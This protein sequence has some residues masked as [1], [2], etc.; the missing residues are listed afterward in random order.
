MAHL[1]GH[2]TKCMDKRERQIKPHK[3][4]GVL[5][6]TVD[7]LLKEDKHYEVTSQR[8][9]IDFVLLARCDCFILCSWNKCVWTNHG[10]KKKDI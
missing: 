7:N 4:I 2:T 3:Y 6:G 5:R 1:P 8:L 10:L 9:P